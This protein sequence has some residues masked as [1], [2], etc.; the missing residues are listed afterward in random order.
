MSS[1]LTVLCVPALKF[2]QLQ[3]RRPAEV[4]SMLC[5]PQRSEFCP[6]CLVCKKKPPKTKQKLVTN[7]HRRDKAH[8]EILQA[9]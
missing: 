1:Q 7:L 4:N 2:P 8:F 6:Q 3:S 9:F 5:V